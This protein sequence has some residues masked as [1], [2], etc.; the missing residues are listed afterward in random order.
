MVR[1]PSYHDFT[2]FIRALKWHALGMG[3]AKY[4]TYFNITFI[5]YETVEVLICQSVSIFFVL[6]SSSWQF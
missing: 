6:W 4:M 5:L 2:L 3:V 1:C